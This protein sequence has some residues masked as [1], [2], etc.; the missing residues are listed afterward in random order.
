MKKI[1]YLGPSGIGDWCFIYPSLNALLAKYDAEQVD[2]IVPYANAGNE[3]LPHNELISS[4]RYL[5]RQYRGIGAISYLFRWL[6]L[7]QEIRKV[8]YQAVVISFLSNQP[9]MLL[10]AQLSGCH[11]RVGIHTQAGW[12][13]KSA[14]NIPI[15]TGDEKN[16]LTLHKLYAA[17][18]PYQPSP[19][20]FMPANKINNMAELLHKYHITPPYVILGIGGG[21][22]AQWRFWPA[23]HYA[24]LI[25]S[26]TSFQWIMLG[27]G[28]DDQQQAQQILDHVHQECGVKNLVNKTSM[29]EAITLMRQAHAVVGND[30]GIANLS[31][32]M[33]VPTLCLY[34]P[35]SA[36]LTGP[37]L[38]GAIVLQSK[39]SCRPCFD[40]NMNPN[41][42][43]LCPDKQCLKQVTTQQVINAL[44]PLT[45]DTAHRNEA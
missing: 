23:T 39:L 25:N 12:L 29:F 26:K 27:G 36:S 15:A 35:T 33:K 17:E 14:I 1:L 41:H 4:I 9:D 6:K 8:R 22:G 21:R 10:L 30:S 3:L 28:D 5:K 2:I 13:Q 19:P 16:R 31:A 43:V 42:A 45:T 40:N 38:N 24:E 20:P 37:A 7:L 34:G 44:P 18:A 32:I 11:K